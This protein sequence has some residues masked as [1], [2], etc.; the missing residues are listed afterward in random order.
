MKKFLFLFSVILILFGY[1]QVKAYDLKSDEKIYVSGE[2]IGIKL[3]TGVV[4]MGTYGITNNNTVY[5]P[6]KDCD[7]KEGDVIEKYNDV[8]VTNIKTLL[9]ALA[10]SNGKEAKLSLIRNKKRI[11]TIITPAMKEDRSYSLGLYIKDN[12]MGVGTLTYIVPQTNQYGSLGHSI[13]EQDSYGGEVY[14]AEVNEI[15]K[16]SRNTAGEKRA[17]IIGSSIGTINENTNVGVYGDINDSYKYKGLQ[18]MNI[19]KR[20]DVK[21]G[22]AQIM[23]CINGTTIENF[24]IEITDLKKQ[25]TKDVKGIKFTVT[26]EKMLSKCG[27][28]VQ[29]MSGSPII[30]DGKIVGAVTHVSLNDSKIGYG[31]YVEFM[32][33]EMDIYIV[34]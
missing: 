34:D 14:R 17:T 21:K 19:T 1:V 2:T 23:T 25:N 28:V 12:I 4:V 22:K 10:S 16:P 27:G 30:Q 6:W 26:D 3:E 24:D 9:R 5:T 13:T 15:I 29:G 33:E 32:L 7:I 11:Q 31:V 8:N 18:L 20:N